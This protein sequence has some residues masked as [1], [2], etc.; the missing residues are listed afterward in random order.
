MTARPLAE[1]VQAN[2]AAME[3]AL[4]ATGYT[5]GIETVTV[6]DGIVRYVIGTAL[7]RD[8]P[9]EDVVHCNRGCKTTN[10]HFHI[11][12]AP[13]AARAAANLA[14]LLEKSP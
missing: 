3:Q 9:T 2:I 13:D 8:E 7:K 5:S 14:A 11:T 4:A 12:P 6:E 1:L 10:P